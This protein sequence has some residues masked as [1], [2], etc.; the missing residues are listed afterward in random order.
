MLRLVLNAV[1][2]VRVVKRNMKKNRRSKKRSRRRFNAEERKRDTRRW[3]RRTG[4]PENLLKTYSERYGI[5]EKE[6]HIEFIELGYGEQLSIQYYEQNEIEWEYKV[7]GYSGDMKI[8]P[9]GVAG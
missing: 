4:T 3:L 2:R 9:K 7:V 6:S 8:V 1:E 5:S